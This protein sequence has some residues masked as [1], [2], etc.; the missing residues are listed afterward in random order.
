MMLFL[1]AQKAE[2]GKVK[3][4]GTGPEYENQADST[5]PC[6][7]C[8]TAV[9][10]NNSKTYDASEGIGDSPTSPGCAVTSF[11]GYVQF[12]PNCVY[13]CNEA[14]GQSGSALYYDTS[15]SHLG[16]GYI[17][18]RFTPMSVLNP[19]VTTPN[20]PVVPSTIDPNAP[21]SGDPIGVGSGI[22]TC[23]RA[24]QQ[25][26]K[27]CDL[28]KGIFDII[29][30]IESILFVI[31]VLAFVIGGIIYIT[32]SGE[33][34]MMEMGKKTIMNAVIGI[35]IVLGS[36]LIVS[37]VI[38]YLGTKTNMGMGNVTWNSFD[39]TPTTHNEGP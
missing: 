9:S 29:K 8:T 10:A 3:I 28:I 21:I 38:R 2:A 13:K 26:C 35:V 19:P 25:M 15:H 7:C 32:S 33:S 27:L 22:V 4:N 12:M 36:F 5:K 16:N 6:F 14:V 1:G 11:E 17:T 37:T 23:G 31:F 30:Y 34:G 24:G 39:C 18:N 20:P